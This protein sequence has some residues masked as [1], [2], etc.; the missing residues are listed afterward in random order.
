MRKAPDRD[1]RGLFLS[2]WHGV[3]DDEF[4]PG[5]QVDGGYRAIR[6]G[7]IFVPP[8]GQIGQLD[9][10]VQAVAEVDG[11]ACMTDVDLFT[12]SLTFMVFLLWVVGGF[13][14]HF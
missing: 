13:F 3:V 4:S 12:M 5:L 10:L 14:L 2:V 9:R 11:A 7:V 6:F 1:G 8:C